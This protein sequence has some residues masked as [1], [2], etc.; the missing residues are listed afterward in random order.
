MPIEDFPPTIGVPPQSITADFGDYV[1]FSVEAYGQRPFTYQW[2]KGGNPIA[3]ATGATLDISGIQLSDAGFYSVTV[4]NPI[5]S[6]TSEE[7]RLIVREDPEPD[8]SSGL[9]SYWPF[10]EVVDEGDGTYT[11]PDTYSGND[12]LLNLMD[13]SSL[14]ASPN[15]QALEFNGFDQYASRQGGF[16]V[17][18]GEAYSISLWVKGDGVLQDDLRIFAEGSSTTNTPLFGI[19]TDNPGESGLARVFVRS[20]DNAA[21]VRTSSSVVFDDTWHHLVYVDNNGD[22]NLYVDGV[23][24]PTDFSYA[25]GT[26]TLDQTS[27]GAILRAA[28]SHWFFGQIDEVAVWNRSITFT[29]IQ[30]IYSEGIPEPTAPIPAQIT[31]QPVGAELWAGS[32]VALSVQAVGT[33]P[34][35]FQWYKDD[36]EIPGATGSTLNFFEA[37]AADSG[38]YYAVATNAVGSDQS[39]SAVLN[40]KK[41][42]DV[43]TG[44]VAYYPL[45]EAD[46]TTTPDMINGYDMTL[47]NM[48]ASN[49]VPGMSGQ[50]MTFDGVEELLVRFP[51][52]GEGLP[53][54]QHPQFTVCMWVNG[55]GDQ[56]D[57]RAFSEGSTTSQSPLYNIGTDNGGV[58]GVLDLFIRNDT[59][60]GTP[61]NHLK[62]TNI[63]YDSTWHHVA[64]VDDA[65]MVSIYIDGV[66]DGT[67][68]SYTRGMLT[69]NTTSIGGIQR[70][71]ASHWLTGTIDEV[72]LWERPLSGSEIAHVMMN[73]PVPQPR[74]ISITDMAML[75]GGDLELTIETMNPSAE[76][77][78]KQATSLE[79]W[80]WADVPGATL[81]DPVGNVITATIPAPAAQSQVY[82]VVSLPPPPLFFDDCEGGD[83]G[84]T[85]GG[86]EDNWELGVPT[87]GPG[88]ALSP[89]NVWATGLNDP[90][91]VGTEAWLRS[92]IIDLTGVSRAQLKF[93][94]YRDVEPLFQGLAFD[95]TTLRVLDADNLGGD[96][97][98]TLI[99]QDVGTTPDWTR[100]TF[101]LTTPVV[102]KRIILEFTLTS[103]GYEEFPQFGWYLDDIEITEE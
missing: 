9:I 22:A 15:N 100:R 14:V 64:V 70:A 48:D 35:T 17:A 94:E 84:W 6:A 10:D 3:G 4:T 36:V 98:A 20:D 63:A 67:S 85:H 92:P 2:L 49:L 23:Q 12:M 88:S 102:G 33:N 58:G 79:A 18:G 50:A 45:D 44:L 93:W 25:R 40:V 47:V 82:R 11:T 74:Q 28:P 16:P 76:H 21:N 65:G 34:V 71:V 61:V 99:Q 59:D 53:I 7:A 8:V 29:E 56:P 103:D 27:V 83:L 19:G 41:I 96:P 46:G 68:I 31:V 75:P 87:T 13:D 91:E 72:I 52:E 43:T 51:E 81:S 55:P 32:Q 86:A 26:L 38:V 60:M 90:Y 95:Y 101:Q 97:L 80:D 78:L 69:A 89:V 54:Y 62:S 73:G 5:G 30:D 24:D 57:R 77:M 66:L 37:S 42:N 39:E 1:T